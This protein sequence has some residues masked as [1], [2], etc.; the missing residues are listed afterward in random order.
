M[1][2]DHRRVCYADSFRMVGAGEMDCLLNIDWPVSM[3]MFVLTLVM[4]EVKVAPLSGIVGYRNSIACYDLL[5][6]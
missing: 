6:S 4:M 3:S 5:R 2:N 1:Y